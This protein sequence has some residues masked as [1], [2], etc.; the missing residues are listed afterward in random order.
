MSA[1]EFKRKTINIVMQEAYEEGIEEGKRQALEQIKT[2]K[3]QN[4]K[5]RMDKDFS[6][7]PERNIYAKMP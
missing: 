3:E 6:H 4:H 5:L 7:N 1:E 2:L